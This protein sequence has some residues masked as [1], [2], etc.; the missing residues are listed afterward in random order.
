M[1]NYMHSKKSLKRTALYD[2][3]LRSGARLVDFGGWEMPVQY[4]GLIDEHIACRTQCGLFDVSHMGELLVEGPRSEA[5]L[6]FAVTNSV[7][8]LAITQAQYNV[9]CYPKG[10]AVDDLVIYKRSEETFLAVVNA[11]NALKDYDYLNSLLESNRARFPSVKLTDV[12]RSFSQIAIQGRSSHKV[13]GNICD[14]NLQT[15]KPYWFSEGKVLGKIP[16]II[17]R[18]GYTG[19]DGFEIYLPWEEGP[20]LWRALIETGYPEGLRPCGLGARDTLRLEMKYALY[21]HELNDDTTPLEAGLGWVVKFSKQDFIGKKALILEREQGSKRKLIGLEVTGHGI[22][23]GG[24]P[25]YLNDGSRPIGSV[26]S[27][28]YS[29]SL[30]KAIAIAFVSPEFSDIGKELEVDIRGQRIAARVVKTPF[31]ARPY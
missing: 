30:K 12:S 28:T 21:G 3:H 7:S 25:I 20:K 31:Y 27:G 15:M 2:E 24:Y 26:T 1:Q 13:I 14:V 22:A 9:L 23:R 11:S 29:P 6:D 8:S 4:S 19:E 16:A 17:S 18:T 5:F 10:T